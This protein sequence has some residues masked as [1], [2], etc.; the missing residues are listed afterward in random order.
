MLWK[1]LCLN[2]QWLLKTGNRDIINL[3]VELW[4]LGTRNYINFLEILNIGNKTHYKTSTAF[5]HCGNYIPFSIG[6]KEIANVLERL[7]IGI[8][9][10]A[11]LLKL[12]NIGKKHY[13]PSEVF[14][15]FFSI[16][17]KKCKPFRTFKHWDQRSYKTSRTFEHSWWQTGSEISHSVGGNPWLW[18][19][20][21]VYNI[22][23]VTVQLLN[24]KGA[25][26]SFT[27]KIRFHFCL[28]LKWSYVNYKLWQFT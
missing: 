19:P 21:F 6:D 3:L 28:Y 2:L 7:S 5:G 4:A 15:I 17:D 11:R 22:E 14:S 13:K 1:E 10:I 23:Y 9:E 24:N 12:L 20:D 16:E 8:K 27:T 18:K 25:P 26:I